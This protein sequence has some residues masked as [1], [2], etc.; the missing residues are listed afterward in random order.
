MCHDGRVEVDESPRDVW[1]EGVGDEID[2]ELLCR[3]H[4]DSPPM[5]EVSQLQWSDEE[6]LSQA[7][8]DHESTEEGTGGQQPQA[9]TTPGLSH[10]TSPLTPPS[11]E[12]LL[13]AGRGGRQLRWPG[14]VG[15]VPVAFVESVNDPDAQL[16]GCPNRRGH[17]GGPLSY[18]GWMGYDRAQR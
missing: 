16:P 7:P 2:R 9:R 11:Y 18:E 15:S 3:L 12:P 4:I 1:I 8:A 5:V 13:T 17:H 14:R 10:G 6:V